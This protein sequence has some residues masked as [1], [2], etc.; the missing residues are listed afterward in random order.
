MIHAAVAGPTPF[1]LAGPVRGLFTEVPPLLASLDGFRPSAVGVGLSPEELGGLAEHF[2][3]RAAEP[4][5][6]LT[7]NETAEVHGLCRFGEV[8]I[9]NPSVVALLEWAGGTGVPVEGLDPSD[10]EYAGL[11]T[12]HVGYLELVG[13]TLRERRLTRTPPTA[14]TADEFAV[15]WHGQ[16]GDG[17]GSQA[18]A[19]ARDR[20]FVRAARALTARAGRVALVVDRERY[21]GVLSRLSENGAPGG[22]VGPHRTA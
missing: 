3:G 17:R 22:A 7:E 6:P 20:A 2:A 4:L 14:A 19:D 10:E 11:F 18:L 21:D 5:V 16:V 9:P 13:R 1:L 15:R 8:R 12:E